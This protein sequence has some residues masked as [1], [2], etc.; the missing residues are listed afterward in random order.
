MIELGIVIAVG[1]ILLERGIN[2]VIVPLMHRRNGSGP[3]SAS[4]ID[5][6]INDVKLSIVALEG[7]VDMHHEMTELKIDQLGQRVSQMEQ[8]KGD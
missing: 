2:L 3:V 4:T 8:G 6:K 7:K 5:G 1:A